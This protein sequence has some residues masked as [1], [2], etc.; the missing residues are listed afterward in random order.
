M[1]WSKWKKLFSHISVEEIVPALLVLVVGLIVI[2]LL[3]KL[4]D[5]ALRRSNLEKTA[6]TLLRSFLKILLLVVLVL[7][8]CSM[9][10]V[11]VTSLVALLSVVTLAIS[12][13]VQNLLTNVISGIILL[14]SKPFKVGDFVEIG[15]NSGTVQELGMLYTKIVTAD[16]RVVSIP[17]SNITANEIVNQTAGGKRRIDISISASYDAAPEQVRAALLEVAGQEPRA[18]FTPEPAVRVIQYGDNAIEYSLQV[19]ASA[20][21]YWPARFAMTEAIYAAFREAG[22]EMTYPHLNVHLQDAK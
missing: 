7:I 20:E 16:Y 22:I 8:L 10:G 1:D 17:N 13:S 18:L 11:N 6:Y 12:L 14:G 5:T 9:L 4:L 2:K 15:T 3:L 19:W 21:D